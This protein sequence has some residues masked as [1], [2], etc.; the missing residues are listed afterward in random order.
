MGSTSANPKPNDH[1]PLFTAYRAALA[2]LLNGGGE[3]VLHRAYEIGRHAVNDGSSLLDIASAHHAAVEDEIERAGTE[4]EQRRVRS[5]ALALLAEC[6]TP[7]EMAIR[8]HKQS[9]AVLRHFN[10]M[11]EAQAQRIAHTIHDGAGQ[12]LVAVHLALADL[13]LDL[14]GYA[15]R[16][17]KLMQQL[18]KIQAE[19]REVAHELRPT[20]LDHLGLTAALEYLAMNTTKRSKVQVDVEV[21]GGDRLPT[22][23]ETLI[24]RVVS[25]AL[26]NVAAH[27]RAGRARVS[28]RREGSAVHCRVHDDGAGFDPETL[29]ASGKQTLGLMGITERVRAAGGSLAI[30]SA[31]GAGT[32]LRFTVPLGGEK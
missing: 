26:N 2:D 10:E 21:E 31:Q 12:M 5:T 19:L 7:Q 24:Y 22:A 28:V 3:E 20:M 4:A 16:L 30:Q 27:S 9:I 15:P 11:L 25:E 23:V 32:D 8:A 13:E 6:L 14:P 29:R 1:E 17:N 18:E